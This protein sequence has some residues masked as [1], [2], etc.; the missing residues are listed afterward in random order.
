LIQEFV[1]P[2]TLNETDMPMT[3]KELKD[4]LVANHR[5]FTSVFSNLNDEDFVFS[6]TGKWSAGQQAYHILKSV[7][8]VAMLFGLPKFLARL[9]FKIANRPSRSYDKLVEKYLQKL[10]GGGK[11]PARFVPGHVGAERKKALAKKI[12]HQVSRLCRTFNKYSE[13]ELDLLV[14]PH[15]LL[16]WITLR[17]MLYFTIYH[18][19][20]HQKITLRDLA[21]KQTIVDGNVAKDRA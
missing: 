7:S 13:E 3:K 11:A 5:N 14:M 10:E 4:A 12:E 17:E 6:L 9:I 16:G 1:F 8:P 15:P 19:Q 18:V 21:L 2:L 20:H